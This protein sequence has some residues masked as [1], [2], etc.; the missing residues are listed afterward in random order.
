MTE[1]WEIVMSNTVNP[2][3]WTVDGPYK[4][5]ETAFTHY[6]I[7]I[8]DQLPFITAFRPNGF[9]YSENGV[10]GSVDLLPLIESAAEGMTGSHVAHRK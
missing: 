2:D 9:D 10:A 8:R 5:L 4:D 1:Q 3:G 7:W 6:K